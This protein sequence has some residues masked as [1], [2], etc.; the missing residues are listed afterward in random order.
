M[1]G[2]LVPALRLHP[3]PGA[4]AG[5]GGGPGAGAVR[6]AAERR[7]LAEADAARGRFRTFLLAVCRNYLA[8]CRDHD[9]ADKRGGGQATISIDAVEAEGRYRAEPADALTP[10]RLYER[11]WVLALLEQV[12]AQLGREYEADGKRP[13]FAHLEPILAAAAEAKPYGTIAAALGMT[14]GAVQTAAHRLRRRYRDWSATRSPRRWMTRARSRTRSALSS[15][16]WAVD[17]PGTA[18]RKSSTRV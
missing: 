3:P 2:L 4:R 11:T 14:E 7:A 10:E 13:L 12:L 18:G 15:R 16:R 5:R 6:P 9:A 8:D 1:P 17:G